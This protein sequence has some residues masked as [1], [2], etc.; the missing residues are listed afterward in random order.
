MK[1]NAINK[2][3]PKQI[4]PTKKAFQP[5]QDNYIA[6]AKSHNKLS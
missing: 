3:T 1:M 2:A 6:I 4:E 5:N